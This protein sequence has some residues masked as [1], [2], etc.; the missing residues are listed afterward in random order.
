MNKYISLIA[1]ALLACGCN[2]IS[3]VTEKYKMIN[4]ADGINSDDAKLIAQ[5]ELID[6]RYKGPV[7][8]L[9]P[10]LVAHEDAL[11]YPQYCFVSFPSTNYSSPLKDYLFVIDKR[12]AA[13]I[14]QGWWNAQLNPGLGWVF[15]KRKNSY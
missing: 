1:I 2:S 3:T 10:S 6:S 9:M 11:K 8:V 13:I 7:D 12:T 15:E 4:Y 14:Y 5:K